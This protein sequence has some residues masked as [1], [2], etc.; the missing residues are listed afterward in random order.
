[1]TGGGHVL[2]SIGRKGQGPGNVGAP[3]AGRMNTVTRSSLQEGTQPQFLSGFSR[4]RPERASWQGHIV[5][6]RCS[7]TTAMGNQSHQNP[8]ETV[9]P[10]CRIAGKVIFYKNFKDKLQLLCLKLGKYKNVMSNKI[11][12]SIGYT[13]YQL[14]KYLLLISHCKPSKI[15]MQPSWLKWAPCQPGP[16]ALR[17]AAQRTPAAL[18]FHF[19]TSS[20]FIGYIYQF[21]KKKSF[22]FWLFNP[23]GREWKKRPELCRRRKRRINFLSVED[24]VIMKHLSQEG[25]ANTTQPNAKKVF[26]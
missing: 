24:C 11:N 2:A 19:L 20:I 13:W 5:C 17:A 22:P 21:K 25:D 9:L 8:N 14:Q 10:G 26:S 6:L 3:E 1:M 16:V 18:G 23:T 12:I 7:V 4:V 15:N